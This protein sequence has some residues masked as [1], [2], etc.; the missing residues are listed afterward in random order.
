[1][2]KCGLDVD[3]VLADFMSTYHKRFGK[4]KS[5]Y[6]ITKNVQR[7]LK[8]DKDFWINLPVLNTLDFTPTLYCT[9]RVNPKAWTRKWLVENNF[10]NKPI[11]QVYCQSS[12]KANYIKGRIDVFIDDSISNF[13]AMNLAGVP[14]LLY[15][16]DYNQHWGPIG[17][18]YSLE[19]EHIE[20]AYKIFMATFFND[21]KKLL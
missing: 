6:E 21:F 10:P 14:C 4:P 9:K 13:I 19:Y 1:M 2:L 8:S 18:I 17:R 20:R 3:D 15:N 7:I 12:N 11:Y 16:K 5:D